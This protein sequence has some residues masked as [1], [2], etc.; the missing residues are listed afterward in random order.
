MPIIYTESEEK[1]FKLAVSKNVESIDHFEDRF[2]NHALVKQISNL[3]E[4]RRIEILSTQ[5]LVASLIENSQQIPFTKNEMNKPELIE[6][7]DHMSISHS[8][9]YSAAIVST[10]DTGIDIQKEVSKIERIKH[11]FLSDAE[12]DFIDEHF[13]REMMHV[14]WG[15]KESMY[16]AYGKKK[17]TFKTELI[18]NPF[19]Y[20][21]EGF[22]F[23]GRVYKNDYHE[24]F[25]IFARK[26][27][28][29]YLVFAIRMLGSL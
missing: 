26:I 24:N 3:N 29:F 27:E 7:S 17:V 9:D 8:Y 13:S 19:K 28:D 6:S 20:K 22:Q 4:K 23:T 14:M 16:K 11:K 2:K 15:A 10:Y 21:S 12:I 25:E 5:L 18:I 1:K